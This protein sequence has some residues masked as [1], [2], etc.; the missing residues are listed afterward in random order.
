MSFTSGSGICCVIAFL[1]AG[2]CSAL[3]Q[4]CGIR[5]ASSQHSLHQDRGVRGPFDSIRLGSDADFGDPFR[6]GARATGVAISVS[7]SLGVERSSAACH[8]C[9]GSLLNL[10]HDR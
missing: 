4:R 10:N 8:V 5:I 7:N 6:D 1:S 3:V 9:D 2:A